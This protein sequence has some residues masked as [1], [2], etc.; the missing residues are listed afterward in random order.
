MAGKMAGFLVS[1]PGDRKIPQHC[2]K[3]CGIAS[4]ASFEVGAS[5]RIAGK[6]AR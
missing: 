1:D 2:G 4:S 6:I 5:R 3:N